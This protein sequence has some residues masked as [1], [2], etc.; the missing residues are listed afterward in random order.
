MSKTSQTHDALAVRC[1]AGRLGCLRSKNTYGYHQFL[2]RLQLQARVKIN[3]IL[4]HYVCQYIET[5]QGRL[6]E[7]LS[8][9][10]IKLLWS[11]SR[12][13]TMSTPLVNSQM[14]K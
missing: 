13:L 9:N 1:Y 8:L 14:L 3:E 2:C 5:V 4:D 7:Q 6:Q 12:I 10:Y 11:R